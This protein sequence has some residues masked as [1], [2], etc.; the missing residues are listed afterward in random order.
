MKNSQDASWMKYEQ[1]SRWIIYLEAIDFQPVE[2][3]KKM[4]NINKGN[5]SERNYKKIIFLFGC[6]F[7]CLK[8]TV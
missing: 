4:K 3:K 6:L 8:V 2:K 1:Q 7:L 5:S